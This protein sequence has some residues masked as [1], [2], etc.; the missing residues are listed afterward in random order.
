MTDA[1]SDSRGLPYIMKGNSDDLKK[2]LAYHAIHLDNAY[3]N[4]NN[5]NAYQVPLFVDNGMHRSAF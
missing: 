2:R 3:N 1:A 4:S 5:N